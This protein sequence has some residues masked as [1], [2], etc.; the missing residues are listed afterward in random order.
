VA[1]AKK[2]FGLNDAQHVSPRRRD[3]GEGDQ[4]D[5]IEPR[6]ARPGDRT[7]QHRELVSE[8]GQLGEQRPA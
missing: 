5:P 6:D 4:G 8:Q 1:P 3:G 7:L 2:R